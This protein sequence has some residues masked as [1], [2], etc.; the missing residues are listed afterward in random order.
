MNNESGL[1]RLDALFSLVA[2]KSSGTKDY[3]PGP[4]PFVTSSELNNGVVGY[5]EP[6]ESDRIFEGPVIAVSGLGFATVQ[7]SNFLPKGNG[8]DSITVLKPLV[9]MTV[10]QLVATAAAFNSLHS[11]RFSFGRKASKGRLQNLEVPYPPYDLT[12]HVKEDIATINKMT[13]LFVSSI[14]G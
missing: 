1:R 12:S 7:L 10:L 11:W 2:A 13:E 8:G 9:E 4:V 5:V 14:S 3:A 6:F